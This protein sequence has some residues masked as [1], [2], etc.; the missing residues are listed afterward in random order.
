MIEAYHPQISVIR[1]CNLVGLPRAS[2]YYQP[3]NTNLE[4][5]E[6]LRCM[7][8][9][10]R[11]YTERPFYGSRRMTHYLHTQGYPVN[12]KRV[13]RLLHTMGLV[14]IYPRR[15]TSKP[16][17]DHKVYPYLLR[18]LK[19][20]RVD[21]VWCADITYIPLAHGFMF[22]VA[23]M[24][25]FSRYVLSWRLS[26]SLES[27]FCLAALEEALSLG[28]PD[29][30]NTD[31]GSQFTSNDF[32]GRLIDA[33]INI[34]MDGRGRVMDNIFIERL[35][36]SLKYEDIYL[37]V[38]S[39]SRELQTG[40]KQYFDFY[41]HERPHQSLGNNTPASLCLRTKR[42]GSKSMNKSETI[43]MI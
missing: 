34:S 28:C 18:G 21:Q 35:W 15:K 22:L 1:Q 26:N 29:I 27:D 12:R 7:E 38:Y 33:H 6:N 16:A 10:D 32:T 11:K 36:R 20:D 31:Q 24:D 19:I 39:N 25:W 40:I 23:I 5:L 37:K 17:P 8:L 3:V 14:A 4:S 41:N 13:Q 42:D 43:I 9:I 2:Y 30:F